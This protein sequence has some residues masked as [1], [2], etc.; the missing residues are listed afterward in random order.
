MPPQYYPNMLWDE[1]HFTVKELSESWHLTEKVVREMFRGNKH[2]LR[3]VRPESKNKRSYETLRI[4]ASVAE[5]QW[6]QFTL[7][8]SRRTRA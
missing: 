1:R 6:H 3:I 2:V 4:P 5:A 8:A 7:S